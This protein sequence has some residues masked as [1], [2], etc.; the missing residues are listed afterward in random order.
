MSI[1]PVAAKTGNPVILTDGKTTDY[2]RNIKS[3]A[4]GGTSVLNESFDNFSERLNG[5]IDLKL[6]K[7]L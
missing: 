7:M 2:K 3:Y 4:I 1:A 5:K 6:I